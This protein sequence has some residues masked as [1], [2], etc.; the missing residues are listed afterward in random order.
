MDVLVRVLRL[1]EQQLGHYQV[2]HEVLDLA[3]HEDHPLLQQARVYVV[4]A[5]ATGGLLD[6]H[7]HQAASGLDIRHLLHKRIAGH[8]L[9][10][11]PN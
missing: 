11:L 7:R 5:F 10:S 9:R 2:G 3:D 6:D 8:V 1:Q 4:G